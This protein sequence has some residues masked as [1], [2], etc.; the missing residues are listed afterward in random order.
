MMGQLELLWHLQNHDRK[1]R[2]LKLQLRDVNK[3]EKLEEL[4]I[5]L[6]G[7]E[8]DITNNKTQRE[9]NE[10][11]IQRY[12]NKLNQLTFHLKEIE[13]KLYGGEVKDVRQLTYMSK[14]A[15][16]VKKEIIKLE[17]DII[18]LMEEIETLDKK[19]ET[20]DDVYHRLEKELE[21]EKK[22]SENLV[23]QLKLCIVNENKILQK[24]LSG[25]ED[26]LKQKYSVLKEKKGKAIAKVSDDKCTGCHMSIPLSILSKLRNTE[27]IVYC[28]NCGRILY[29]NRDRNK[30]Q[31]SL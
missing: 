25:I 29:F 21:N 26:D 15:Q 13:N 23:N 11:K 8:Y 5:R 10:V 20:V 7:I 28:D 4:Q 9:V 2:K 12:N 22:Q 30:E 14:E 27:L 31:T 1:L 6:K 18:N 24:I 16:D 19:L 17:K 3:S